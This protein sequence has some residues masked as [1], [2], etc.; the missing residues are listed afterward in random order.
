MVTFQ[1][2]TLS[3]GQ[4]LLVLQNNATLCP[5]QVDEAPEITMEYI[6]SGLC[7]S[8]LCISVTSGNLN[9]YYHCGNWDEA[10]RT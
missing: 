4:C 5:T 10:L 1:Q 2:T 8:K 3:G 9:A 6:H 7:T